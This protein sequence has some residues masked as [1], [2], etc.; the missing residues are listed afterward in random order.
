MRGNDSL[1]WAC[2]I[3]VEVRQVIDGCEKRSKP[4]EYFHIAVGSDAERYTVGETGVV[5]YVCFQHGRRCVS[6]AGDLVVRP[7][8][9][10]VLQSATVY[11][12]GVGLVLL[13]SDVAITSLDIVSMD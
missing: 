3:A 11:L 1:S 12:L 6:A 4:I 5:E 7:P 10:D 9:H 13:C 8:V 2:A